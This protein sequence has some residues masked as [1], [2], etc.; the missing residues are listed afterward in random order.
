MPPEYG[1]HA[2]IQAPSPPP[3]VPPAAGGRRGLVAVDLV[4][5]HVRGLIERG[6]L[7]P[8]D[9]LPPERELAVQIGVSRPTVRTALRSL[10]TMGVVRSR[11]GAGTF[12]TAGPPAL[13][14][15]P[16]GLLAALHGLSL[17]G[18]FEARL[19]LEVGSSALASERASGEHLAAMSEEVTGMFAS[20]DQ[21]LTFLRHDVRFHRAIAAASGNPVLGVLIEMLGALFYER[22]SETIQRATDLRETAEAHRRIYQAIRARNRDAAITA[23]SEHLRAAQAAQT[24]ETA[25]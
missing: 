15:E 7:R 6:E 11:Q 21:P 16:L 20:I 3:L 12:I 24:V 9:R 19:V 25:H 1:T 5:A 18:L 14:S 23:M 4:T 2:M 8:G 10:A 13:A 17:G 22:R